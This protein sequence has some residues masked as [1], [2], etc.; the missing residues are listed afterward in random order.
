M[1]PSLDEL[2][3]LAGSYKFEDK[4]HQLFSA[5]AQLAESRGE[6]RSAMDMM[7]EQIAVML[8]GKAKPLDPDQEVE[9]SAGD[10]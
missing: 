2:A 9:A 7:H 3:F 8:A 5:L 1:E 10:H 6:D 4:P